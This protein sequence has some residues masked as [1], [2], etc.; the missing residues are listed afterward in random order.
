MK[1]TAI[2]INNNSTIEVGKALPTG[3]NVKEIKYFESSQVYGKFLHEP[4]YVVECDNSTVKQVIPVRSVLF[5]SIDTKKDAGVLP[6]LV[7]NLGD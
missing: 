5:I 7:E 1:I 4:I 6:V 2:T 3:E